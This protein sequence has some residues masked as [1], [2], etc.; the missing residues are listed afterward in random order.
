M[1]QM[2]QLYD[3]A[4]QRAAAS[5][6]TWK[7]VLRL[8]G[9]LYRY[10]WENILLIWIQRPNAVLAADYDSW[11][12]VDR[13]VRRGSRGIGIFPSRAL[14]SHLRYVFD[15]KDTGGRNRKLTW[16][17][18]GPHLK[19]YL[20]YLVESG[21]MEAYDEKG[22]EKAQKN[23]LNVF[24]GT[25]VWSMIKADYSERISDLVR[26]AKGMT[27][28]K[29]KDMI[30]RSVL[31]TVGSRCSLDTGEPD[32]SDIRDYA[33]EEILYRLG[34]LVNDISCEILREF[35]RNIRYMERERRRIYD[36]RDE[37]ALSTKRRPAVSG[38][39][40]T[41]SGSESRRKV[42]PSGHALS[43]R[44]RGEPVQLSLPLWETGGED[45]GSRPGSERDAGRAD[46]QL[47]EIQAPAEPEILSGTVEAAGTGADA[48]GG[49]RTARDRLA[50]PLDFHYD[51]W[52]LPE[53]GPKTRY[54]WNREAI[55]T[56]KRIESEGRR[57]TA[58]EQQTLS[59]YV[60][61]GGL[62]QAFDEQNPGWAKEYAELKGLLNPEEYAAARTSVNTAFYTPPEVAACMGQALEQFGFRSGNILEPSM[63]IGSFFGSMP[64]SLQNSKRYGVELDRISGRIARQL[65]QTAKIQITGFE[66]TAFQADFF[67][68]V[69][70][71]VPF[72][73]YKVHDPAY[74]KYN[75]RI[76]DYFIAKAM[77]LVR[78]GGMVAVITTKGTMDK[79]NPTVRKYLAER[80]ELKG[81][82]RLPSTAFKAQAGA[83]VTA[84]I[85]FF[86]KR[87]RKME[88]EPNWVHLGY[89]ED[90]IAV[91]S[92]FAEHPEM[93][94]GR[95]E[96][97]NGPF[98]ADSHYTACVNRDPDFNLYAALRKAIGN[99]H[100]EL[101]DFEQVM[102]REETTEEIIPADPEVKNYTFTFLNGKLYYRE[103]SQ[104]YLREVSGRE[105]ERI[106]GIDV[107]RNQVR[108]LIRLE[109]GGCTAAELKPEL[110]KLNQIYD[111]Y[112]EEYGYLTGTENGRVFRDD[113]DYPLL[114]SLECV[115]ENGAVK[116]ADIFYKQTIKPDVRVKH[117][118]TATEALYISMNERG[119]VD[120]EFMY[121]LYQPDLLKYQKEVAEVTGQQPEEIAFTEAEKKELSL[122]A[123]A[124][125]LKGII[126]LNPERYHA[127]SPWNG[128]EMAGEYLSGNV[129][130]KLKIAQE[131][132]KKNPEQFRANVEALELVQ[133]EYISAADINV[134]LGTTWIDI[135]DYEAFLYELLDTPYR[136]QRGNWDGRYEIRIQLNRYNMEYHILNKSMHS[137]GVLV[138]KNYGTERMDAYSIVEETLNLRTVVVNDREELGGGK[139]RYVVNKVETMLAREKQNQIQE[140]F[141]EW[142]FRDPERRQK[143]ERYYNETFN[144]IRL[145]EYDGSFL[146]FPGM[147]PEIELLPHQ[148]NAVARI[149][150]GGNTLLAHCVG[151]GKTFEM[152]AACKEQKRLG[153]AHKTAMVVPK[154]VIMQTASEFLRLYPSANIL[155]A[156]ERD[157]EKSRRQQFISR[158]ATGDYD[159][160]I[161]SHSQ[162][163]KIQISPERREQLLSDKVEELQEAIGEEKMK[164]GERWTIKQMEAQ[165][166]RLETQLSMLADERRKDDLVYF[167]ELGI[168]SIMVDEAHFYKN[169]AIFSKMSRVSGIT[170]NGAKKC[171]DME[172]KCQYLT[173]LN[174]SRGIVFATGTP[175]SNTMCEMYVMQ[176]YLQKETLEQMGL[177]HFDA[178]AANFGEVTTAL[179][180]TV[181]GSGFRF[182]SR[183]NR[184][185]NLP[186]LMSMFREVADVQTAEMLN[187][188]IP[189]L[190]GGKAI[191]VETEP[192]FYVKDLMQEMVE[193]AD[194]IRNGAVSPNEDNFL[195]ITHEARLLGTDARLLRAD[196]PN[197]PDGKLNKVVENVFYEYKKAEADGRIGCQLIFSDI[198]TPGGKEFD[199]YHYIKD[200]LMEQGIPEEEIA[201][202]HD[203]KTDKQRAALFREMR[204][205]K[206]RIL[207]G[208]TEKCGVG[209]NVQRHIVAIH[210]VDC[211]WRPDEIE[212]RDGRGLRQGN[213]NKEVAVYR[214]V[215]KETFDAYNW[216]LIENKQR[217]ISQVMTNQAVG[218]TCEDIDEKVLSYAEI[219]A[220]ATGNPLIRE[221][222]E[223]DNEVQKLRVLK[224]AYQNQQYTMQDQLL[225]RGP[226][227]LKKLEEKIKAAT[228]DEATVLKTEGTEFRI[229]IRGEYY[230]EREE[231]GKALLDAAALSDDGE[232]LGEYRGFSLLLEKGAG[233]E[234][235]VILKGAAIYRTELSKSAVGNISRLDNRIKE[236][237]LIKT[238]YL[239]EKTECEREMEKSRELYGKP[240][241]QEDAYRAAV[242]RQEELNSLLDLENRKEETEII[243]E[244]KEYENVQKERTI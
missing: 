47:P 85:L 69:I 244:D 127:Q 63:G 138:K 91:N 159:C 14:K 141:R 108:S 22:D 48:G 160:I 67:D 120:L 17:L 83:E 185:V 61:W 21:Q 125:E 158:I 68:V 181:E 137:S 28:E 97:D 4:V 55:Q 71:N 198:G 8:N 103:N 168:D 3:T 197:N 243:T 242:K 70:G 205:G 99:I 51:L 18:E 228:E 216:S 42:R 183:F 166:K 72:G 84:D 213:E 24:T 124:E 173:E 143:Y 210:H 10:E 152:V 193:R 128:W 38:D 186:E 140:A 144:C 126:Y 45:A 56:L 238:R 30:Y 106:Q 237:S 133:P 49:D 75:F 219:K 233:D 1:Y 136:Y 226:K 149:L 118:D 59:K 176:T 86:Q 188:N 151:A 89:T 230:K 231:A 132:A 44:E 43:E 200:E 80:A 165:K 16:D 162:F 35:A 153:I 148:K 7:E 122:S 187:L 145:R 36:G 177:S 189:K 33:D 222:M 115:E 214:Y 121:G 135:E 227:E 87:E 167:E 52:E 58:E 172:M 29:A 171:T 221:K 65:Y 182:K 195:K 129:R 11:K 13:Y 203:A 92:Y 204:S 178:W 236:M 241:P 93:M 234:K 191:I 179:E 223:V 206:R 116:K 139:Y 157:F 50:V 109:L 39:G 64:I 34:T 117:V 100:A 77:D 88:V 9:R 134:R 229:L 53:G 78:P 164:N 37:S 224:A 57:A 113:A 96:Y 217:F 94:L 40:S 110:E 46:G 184:F 211:P 60:G 147:N 225:V 170:A 82:V 201:F 142:I 150:F 76:H 95:M 196:A 207:I 81:A 154:S 32:F 41:R 202:I 2:N 161:M 66:K 169:M 73:D 218:R 20:D 156:T 105:K 131:A 240:F 101:T 107:I 25:N 104:M 27:E 235:E 90:G 74:N 155:I 174:G 114:C 192:D 163:E 23:L 31:Y 112:V 130:N 102:E 199:V 26:T 98:G 6:E 180:L 79:S 119:C 190:R 208:S 215:T 19:E 194:R 123:I 220:I 175:I 239:E 15:F 146:Q 62:S 5:S 54:Q 209:V 111:A 12:K 212:Q 232:K